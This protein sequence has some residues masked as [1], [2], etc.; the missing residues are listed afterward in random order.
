MTDGIIQ[1][2]IEGLLK[3]LDKPP[4]L[5]FTFV[6]GVF[7]LASLFSGQQFEKIWLF[8]LYA[9]AGTIWRYIE[10]DIIGN[11]FTEEI[12]KKVV[13]RRW[14]ISIYHVGNLALFFTLIHYLGFI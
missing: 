3:V 8:F 13:Y 11:T 7:V 2:F 5:I 4:Y 10:R 12:V 14:I 1:K 9:V 6:G